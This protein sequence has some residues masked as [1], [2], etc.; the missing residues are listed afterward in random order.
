[1][2][3]GGE[4]LRGVERDLV[5]QVE[6]VADRSRVDERTVRQRAPEP[7]MIREQREIDERG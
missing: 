7:A 6:P 4:A 2:P 5:K 1:M 3:I